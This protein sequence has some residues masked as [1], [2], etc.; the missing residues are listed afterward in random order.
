MTNSSIYK[1]LDALQDRYGLKTASYLST[2][3]ADL[4][5]EISERLRAARVQAVAKRKVVRLE[6]SG[7]IV[8]SGG[9]A[10]LGWGSGQGFG[11]LAGLGSVL[12]LVALVIG[13]LVINSVQSD[14]RAAEIAEVDAALLTDELPPAAF[15]DPGFIQFLKSER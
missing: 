2:G 14:N 3:A 7:E 6:T 5:H 10:A 8:R 1:Q 13:L 4:S 12:P 9:S 11:W 15:A